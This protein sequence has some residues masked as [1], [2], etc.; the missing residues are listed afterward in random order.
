MVPRHRI[1][2]TEYSNNADEQKFRLY[3]FEI[4]SMILIEKL[5]VKPKEMKVLVIE[6]ILSTK[7]SREALYYVLMRDIQV[8]YLAC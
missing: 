1:E 3:L 2:M 4:L 6:N 7:A 5:I 8:R